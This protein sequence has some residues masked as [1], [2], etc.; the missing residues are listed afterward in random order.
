MAADS[1]GT[2][3]A[4]LAVGGSP[5]TW[6]FGN[7]T[8]GTAAKS[9]VD[10]KALLS[11]W[12]ARAGYTPGN[13]FGLRGIYNTGS[14]VSRFISSYDGDTTKAAQLEVNYTGGDAIIEM[15]MLPSC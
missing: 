14:G 2:L 9:D 15:M 8:A 1:C 3:A 13:Y 10:I 4:N 6:T 12:L 7:W 11:A 5:V